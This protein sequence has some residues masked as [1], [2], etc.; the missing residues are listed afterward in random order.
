LLDKLPLP[1]IDNSG[2]PETCSLQHHQVRRRD[3]ANGKN[4][5]EVERRTGHPPQSAL[6]TSSI[7][8]FVFAKYE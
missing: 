2:I 8:G 3:V 7:G 6:A 4:E 1:I 5:V